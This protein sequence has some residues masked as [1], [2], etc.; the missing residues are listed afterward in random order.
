MRTE[1]DGDAAAQDRGGD[2]EQGVDQGVEVA[3]DVDVPAATA[4]AA[5]PA[6][7]DPRIAELEARAASL[8]AQLE[9]AQEKARETFAQL[10]DEHDRRLRAAAD[11]E[12]FRRR[13]QRERDEVQKFGSERLL[14]DLLPVV[15]NLDR[16]LAAAPPD[17]PLVRGVGMVRKVF[18]EALARHGVEVFSALGKP[19]D[20][21]VHEALA[22]LE[23]E[24]AEPGTVVAEHGR[25]FHLNGRLL[26]PALVAVAP[27]RR[28]PTPEPEGERET[29]APPA[30]P[31][32]PGEPPGG[33]EA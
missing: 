16:A 5:A 8:A 27:P 3:V 15:D 6:S 13:A 22:H 11:L 26:R 4:P 18:E 20:P 12:N 25:G 32:A 17:D 30:Q 24:G 1:R 7:D 23:V 10:K 29:A 14:K 21:R 9:L 2:I 31:A 28:A 33:G 19:F